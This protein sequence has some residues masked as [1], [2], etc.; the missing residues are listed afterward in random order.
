MADYQFKADVIASGLVNEYKRLSYLKFK[1]FH[2]YNDSLAMAL[3]DQQLLYVSFIPEAF[4]EARKI[5]QADRKRLTTL[6]QRIS[7][8]LILGDCIFLTLTFNDKALEKTSSKYRRECVCR[9]LKAHSDY[10][11]G[12]IDFG[13]DFGREHYHAVLVSNHV[14]L[15]AWKHGFAFAERIHSTSNPIKLA[16]Y[17]SKLA[18]HAV[19][20]TCKRNAL[21]YS[22]V[23]FVDR[24]SAFHWA[25]SFLQD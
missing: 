5:A 17:V 19:K 10:Y 1:A 11:V 2:D 12:N 16:K 20:D 24:V 9:F 3:S 15:S 7:Q 8:F 21:I 4:D 13:K 18:N 14:D 22:R 6:R 23:S 25:E